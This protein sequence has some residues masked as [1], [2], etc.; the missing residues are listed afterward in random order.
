MQQIKQWAGCWLT[1]HYITYTCPPAS[2]P[3]VDTHTIQTLNAAVA[4]HGL[5]GSSTRVVDG[6][7]SPPPPQSRHCQSQVLSRPI[8]SRSSTATSS[9]GS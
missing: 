7:L 2:M 5:H 3:Q 4:F 8:M 6:L 1:Q 9:Q